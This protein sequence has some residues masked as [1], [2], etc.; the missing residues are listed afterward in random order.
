MDNIYNKKFLLKTAEL[1]QGEIDAYK[2]VL[3][4]YENNISEEHSL[5]AA[6][7]VE[8]IE[9]RKKYDDIFDEVTSSL[10]GQVLSEE[11]QNLFPIDAACNDAVTIMNSKA[12]V[13]DVGRIQVELK[14]NNINQNDID[15]P[16]RSETFID[17]FNK[18]LNETYLVS[19]NYKYAMSDAIK[20]SRAYPFSVTAA[21]WDD[22]A[23]LGEDTNFKGD[24]IFETVPV[25]NFWWDS[26][27]N[28]IETCEYAF[29]SKMLSY[30]LVCDFLKELGSKGNIE[31]FEAAY[32]NLKVAAVS[33]GTSDVV[34][35]QTLIDNGAVEILSLYRVMDDGKV[36]VYYVMDRK[37]IIGSKN[38]SIPYLP[39]A[40]LK[41]HSIP[42]QFIGMS[43]VRL[44]LPYIKQ[45]HIL[46]SCFT[47]IALSQ[48][49]PTYL[50]SQQSQIEGQDI[51]QWTIGNA[52]G[53]AVVTQADV[54]NSVGMVPTPV[55]H[56]DS[57]NYR[58]ILDVEISKAANVT[59]INN[60]MASKISGAAVQNAVTQSTIKENTSITEL[61]RYLVRIVKI[62]MSYLKHKLP[63]NR[64]KVLSFRTKGG[65]LQEL[66]KDEFSKLEADVFIDAALLRTSKQETQKQDLMTLLQMQM[67]YLGK[68]DYITF[69]D[70]VEK[71]N[72][73][74]KR[75]VI[76]RIRN[77]DEQVK[78]NNATQLV[79]GVMQVMQ[80]VAQNPQA[81]EVNI[82]QATAM[83]LQ[84]LEQQKK[85]GR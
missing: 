60:N 58:N 82:E 27:S 36:T 8:G 33:K 30:R 49:S 35:N 68:A 3:D 54:N 67:Q 15:D 26:A 65:E 50:I 13:F 37:Y 72:L 21:N 51:L 10:K 32:A 38:L 40:I 1:S 23:T 34:T 24:I 44:A 53:S 62:I 55:I 77:Q 2:S 80:E 43:S 84:S 22:K 6:M 71:F 4:N 18:I 46:D 59:D 52:S 48:K 42:S 31:L 12:S 76:E 69:E 75:D 73:P 16:N 45:K 5:V 29:V 7:I 70:I 41:E 63:N 20:Y 9:F 57:L 28:S 83:V 39:F 19:P 17:T 56:T 78:L 61:E 85:V 74:N 66:T 81:P 64:N 14:S 47:T 79:Q 11:T 25:E